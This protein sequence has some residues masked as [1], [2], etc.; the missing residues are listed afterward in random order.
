[1][2][3]TQLCSVLSGT[4]QQLETLMGEYF[5]SRTAL[6]GGGSEVSQNDLV[7]HCAATG[8]LGM[9]SSK[10]PAVS[11]QKEKKKNLIGLQRDNGF[12]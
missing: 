3:R 6:P 4:E 9:I 11:L 12:P 2:K 8:V 10:L 1:M 7:H 5:V